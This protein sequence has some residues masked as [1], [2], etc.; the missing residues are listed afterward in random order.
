MVV[1]TQIV[2]GTSCIFRKG[3]TDAG[4]G[5]QELCQNFVNQYNF[6]EF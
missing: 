5:L 2:F 1:R 3:Y 4:V 6:F